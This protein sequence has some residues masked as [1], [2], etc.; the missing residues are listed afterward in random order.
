MTGEFF[1][2]EGLLT[3]QGQVSF[4]VELQSEAVDEI[5][6]LETSYDAGQVAFSGIRTD[7]TEV[8]QDASPELQD[9]TFQAAY[10]KDIDQLEQ[11][12]PVM[13]VARVEYD[14]GLS[15]EA[16]PDEER[17]PVTFRCG[18]GSPMTWEPLGSKEE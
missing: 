3:D 8:E 14:E 9:G 4:T 5:V 6:E 7:E 1:D 11:F 16:N 18:D 12:E 17:R 13:W 15:D 10:P 2:P